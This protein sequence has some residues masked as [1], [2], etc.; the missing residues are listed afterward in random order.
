VQSLW[1]RLR[2]FQQDG[3]EISILLSLLNTKDTTP[4][5][6]VGAGRA[7]REKADQKNPEAPL[8]E[9]SRQGATPD[10]IRSNSRYQGD[11]QPLC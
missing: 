1:K 11:A 9:C 2:W 8:I 6:L 10:T 3:V 5:R 4:P 7:Q